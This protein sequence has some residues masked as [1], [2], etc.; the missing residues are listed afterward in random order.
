MRATESQNNSFQVEKDWE[1]NQDLRRRKKDENRLYVDS[2]FFK[3]LF[4]FFSPLLS[5]S[6][7]NM[8]RGGERKKRGEAK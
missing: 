3:H 1:Q 2:A 4:L 5:Y 8:R 6:F 7:T